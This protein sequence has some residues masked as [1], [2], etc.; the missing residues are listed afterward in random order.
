MITEKIHKYPDPTQHW[1]VLVG[2]YCH[3]LWMVGELLM[4]S[5]AKSLT[6][7]QRRMSISMS[8]ISTRKS[9]GKNGI[10]T[11]LG[12]QDLMMRR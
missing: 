9:T 2:D 6:R 5:Q 7:V 12:R 8:F 10:H 11:K 4:G 1:A 3:E